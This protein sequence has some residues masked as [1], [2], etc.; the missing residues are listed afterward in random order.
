MVYLRKKY[1]YGPVYVVVSFFL[2]YDHCHSDMIGRRYAFV[3][4]LICSAY[5]HNNR[6]AHFEAVIIQATSCLSPPRFVA[7]QH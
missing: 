7:Q 6:H 5:Q 1:G 4:P 2:L 3:G